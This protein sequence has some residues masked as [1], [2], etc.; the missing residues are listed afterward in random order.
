MRGTCSWSA[1]T[2]ATRLVDYN[3]KRSAPLFA[4]AAGAVVLGLAD[5]VGPD[6]PG[7]GGRG[8]IGPIVL[9]AD[10]S[11]AG[12]LFATIADR[13]VRNPD[14]QVFRHAVARMSEVTL[15]AIARG[16]DPV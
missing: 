2:S 5:P 15:D 16:G 3:D 11:H 14:P 6:G 4:D 8:A 10:G 13:K 12:T 9:G 1:P 7:A